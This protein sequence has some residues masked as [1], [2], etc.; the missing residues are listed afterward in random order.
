[1]AQLGFEG[2]WFESRA[3]HRNPS[4]NYYSLTE[5]IHTVIQFFAMKCIVKFFLKFHS[6][7]TSAAPSWLGWGA[8]MFNTHRKMMSEKGTLRLINFLNLKI[9]KP[10]IKPCYIPKSNG[11]Q[12]W[13]ITHTIIR[14]IKLIFSHETEKNWQTGFGK[15][16]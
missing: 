6:Y 2:H 1:M 8:D 7:G 14:A 10:E 15:P 11:L 12:Q 5:V 3:Y 9:R 16:G 4:C 13:N